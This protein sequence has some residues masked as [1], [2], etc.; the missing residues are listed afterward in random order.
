[1][2][3]STNVRADDCELCFSVKKICKKGCK[4]AGLGKPV[5]NVILGQLCKKA[6]EEIC[7]MDLPGDDNLFNE[8]FD[9][10]TAGENVCAPE[11]VAN[12]GICWDLCPQLDPD[13]CK[14]FTC[15]AGEWCNPQEPYEWFEFGTCQPCDG[16]PSSNCGSHAECSQ[17]C[18]D[19]VHGPG[20]VDVDCGGACGACQDP[21]CQPVATQVSPTAAVI[22]EETLFFVDGTCL[23]DSTAFW[24]DGCAGVTLKT[25][26]PTL[27]GFSCTPTGAPGVKAGVVKDAPGGKELLTFNVTYTETCP[28]GFASGNY[29]GDPGLS[30]TPDWL[31]SCDSTSGEAQWS[32]ISDCAGAGCQVNPPGQN[33]VCMTCGGLGQTC[34]QQSP[35]CSGNLSCQNGT[36]EQVMCTPDCFMKCGGASDG[37][38]GSCI[39]CPSGTVCSGTTCVNC[40]GVAEPC[41]AQSPMC[42][43]PYTCENGTCT[44]GQQCMEQNF[45]S[46][47][48]MSDID[49]DGSEWDSGSQSVQ[50]IPV[51]LE[52]QV[53]E[54]VNGN[55]DLQARVCK[56]EMGM[57][58]AIMNTLYLEIYGIS[59]S[60]ELYAGGVV[61]DL[62]TGDTCTVWQDLTVQQPFAQGEQLAVTYRLVS[63]NGSE[64]DWTYDC[65]DAVTPPGGACWWDPL[66]DGTTQM[67][68]TC[69]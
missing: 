2:L 16:C 31:Y 18:G 23:P 15:T 38:G 67:T 7:G 41:C 24:I 40:G 42:V 63:P 46:P 34:C 47:T 3:H 52:L 48:S 33:D 37:C 22:G 27:M 54:E 56:F 60:Q 17:F 39:G 20:E 25:Q 19:G 45:W 51:A 8:A 28:H 32:L 58:S 69:L 5:C 4:G 64:A 26:N 1:M 65:L 6:C 36:C 11:N 61:P 13:C 62:A 68:R 29:C 12:D 14:P 66:V 10:D 35:P 55:H 43:S 57:P 50:P 53:R 44:S 21:G 59:P 9:V 30:Q 49:V